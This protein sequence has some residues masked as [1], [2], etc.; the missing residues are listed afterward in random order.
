MNSQ[1]CGLSRENIIHK[2]Q[3]RIRA[4]IPTSSMMPINV[5]KK[6]DF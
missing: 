1:V 4:K 5:S 3:N 2:P 6:D